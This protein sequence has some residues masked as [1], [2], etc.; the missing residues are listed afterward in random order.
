MI[1]PLSPDDET[2]WDYCIGCA[3]PIVVKYPNRP[4]WW[5]KCLKCQALAKKLAT[6][7]EIY[8]DSLIQNYEK[9]E[10]MSKSI[11]NE[12][13]GPLAVVWAAGLVDGSRSKGTKYHCKGLRVKENTHCEWVDGKFKAIIAV[14]DLITDYSEHKET[15]EHGAWQILIRIDMERPKYMVVTTT[16]KG[17][18]FI[19]ERLIENMLFFK[20][21]VHGTPVTMHEAGNHLIKVMRSDPPYY[22]DH[23]QKKIIVAIGERAKVQALSEEDRHKVLAVISS[24]YNILKGTG[25]V[26]LQ[27]MAAVSNY[28]NVE[29]PEEAK[30]EVLKEEETTAEPE[31]DSAAHMQTGASSSTGGGAESG[32]VILEPSELSSWS[33]RARPTGGRLKKEPPTE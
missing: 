29:I 26:R 11:L 20:G 1:N 13:G 3:A 15:Q 8:K 10:E 28:F 25:P 30:N 4:L 24:A 14:S 6:L 31:A 32:F 7:E 27:A 33:E 5:D 21:K 19:F 23:T 18:T 12:L 9:H 16:T 17:M 22:D 2:I